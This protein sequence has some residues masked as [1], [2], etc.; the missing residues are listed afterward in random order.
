MA[1]GLLLPLPPPRLILRPPVN[2]CT[3]QRWI[4]LLHYHA[5]HHATPHSILHVLY[6]T[7][8]LPPS[9]SCAPFFKSSTV[10]GQHPPPPLPVPF[11]LSTSTQSLSLPCLIP[12]GHAA[13]CYHHT[14]DVFSRGAPRKHLKG[15]TKHLAFKLFPCK[16]N[17]LGLVRP[18]DLVLQWY[19]CSARPRRWARTGCD[20]DGPASCSIPLGPWFQG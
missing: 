2:T 11:S 12:P 1:K 8:T 19:L 20:Q 10:P 18:E 16:S 17:P 14:A 9:P 15:R 6:I 13:Q 3:W 5:P 4:S 7:Y